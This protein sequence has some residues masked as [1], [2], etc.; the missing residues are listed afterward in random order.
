MAFALPPLHPVVRNGL[1]IWLAATL[2][3]SIL[4]WAGLESVV[5]V[6]LIFAV[7]FVNENDLTPASSIGQ[8]IAGA[9]IGVLTAQVLHELSTSWVMLGL[10]LLLSGALVRS[11]GMLKGLSTSLMGCWAL[12]LMH[13]GNQVD[14]SVVLDLTF[15]AIVGILMAQL[16]T[17][18]VWPR[19]PL[20]QFPALEAGLARELAQQIAAVQQWLRAGGPPPPPLRSQA[21][22]PRIQQ[23]QH[24]PA[25]PPGQGR[26]SPSARLVRRWAQA[27]SL[28]NQLLRQWL[29]LER[30]LQQLPAP[31]PSSA[32]A[33][34]G[35][36]LLLHS[37]EELA[38]AL[39]HQIAPRAGGSGGS[40]PQA[41]L[42]HASALG[43]A[44]PLM[45]AIGQQDNALQG[46]LRSRGLLQA[47]IAD[48]AAANP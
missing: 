47:A 42:E 1:R 10:A 8:V 37:L 24:L 26:R 48:L 38:Q 29:V 36:G 31:L 7:L 35:D 28:W 13:P 46:L 21:L 3:S 15:A 25:Q 2:A 17:W 43:A 12:D 4:L 33:S 40:A 5:T 6:G 9:L 18:A 45:L 41:W 11:L 30:L 20:Q 39:G 44:K 27:G 32:Q 23:L 22:L 34:G 14:W 16:A 19:R